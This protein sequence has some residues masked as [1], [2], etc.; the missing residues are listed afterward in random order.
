MKIE[1]RREICFRKVPIVNREDKIENS[2]SALVPSQND[3]NEKP[4]SASEVRDD[5]SADLASDHLNSG[6]QTG[7][8]TNVQTEF[9]NDANIEGPIRQFQKLDPNEIL[10]NRI[11]SCIVIGVLAVVGLVAS[12]IVL[13]AV[14]IG[15]V[16]W[17]VVTSIFIP[18]GLLFWWGLTW[19][20][21][22]HRHI[23]W[24][25]D[26]TGFEIQQGVFWRHQISV[27]IARV[28]HVDVSQGPL[29]RNF[30]LGTVTIHTAG[31]VNASVGIEGLAFETA[32]EIRDKLIAQKEALDVV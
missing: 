23:R 30:G 19:P 10:L 26:E 13:V 21:I 11:Q 16:F 9:N 14:G 18:F 2:E 3:P 20:K 5:T 31:T 24:C 27:P 4:E 25:L 28:Q 12:S 32:C 1:S 7:N 15:L 8:S 22:Q 6:L 29:Q 17:I